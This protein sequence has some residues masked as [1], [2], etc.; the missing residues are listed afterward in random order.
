MAKKKKAPIKN[1]LFAGFG[2]IV[3]FLFL[4]KFIAHEE[5]LK[6][7][8]FSFYPDFGIALPVGFSIHGIDV[9]RHQEN[10]DWRAVSE[11]NANGISVHF[12]FIK[13]T[14]G[15]SSTDKNFKKNWK[16]ATISGIVCGAYHYFIATK[17][18]KDQAKNFIK[19]VALKS[20]NLPPVIDVEELYGAN[21]VDMRLRMKD[22]LNL[23]EENYHVK[24]I[25][26]TSADFY[27]QYL[28]GYFNEYPLWVAHYFEKE[29]PR[30]SSPWM[31]WQHNS[32][33]HVNGISEKVDFNIFAGDSTAF[34]EILI[35]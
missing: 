3:L 26:Y 23:V 11:M 9:S 33:G 8:H 20:G 5:I 27:N 14:E 12:A 21:P 28:D 29:K 19:T 32:T 30:V 7:V 13:A 25:I 35:K 18:G 4:Y 17:S 34:E 6:P 15:I 10:I 16:D 1:W 31:F 22:W 2:L 24:P